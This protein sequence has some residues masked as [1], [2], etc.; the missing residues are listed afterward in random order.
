MYYQ[1]GA[2]VF[3]G[4]FFYMAVAVAGIPPASLL[5]L[6]F[7]F[8]RLLPKLS[9]IQRNIQQVGNTLPSYAAVTRMQARF[10]QE[11]EPP[12]AEPAPFLVLEKG[13]ELRR[14]WFR[15]NKEDEIYALQDVDVVIPAG[16]MTAIIGPSGSGKSTLADLIMGLLRPD[17]G[18]IRVEGRPL[19]GERLYQWRRSVGYVPQETFL[20]H[21]T[22][23]ANLL[24]ALPGAG[25]GDLWRALSLAVADEFVARMP[26]GLDTVVGERGLRLSGGE[27]QRIALARALLRQPALLLLDEATSSL[28]RENEDRIL[29]AVERLHGELTILVIAHRLSTIRHADQIVTMERGRAMKAGRSSETGD[30]TFPEGK[31]RPGH[32]QSGE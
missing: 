31:N 17:R 14:V 19:T 8:A 6:V 27:R 23:R 5:V 7:L 20:F 4:L 25:E 29:E 21:D 18:E 15:Y 22:V 2:A 13:I 32:I 26:Q 10:E 24:W 3:L 28:D 30:F 9:Q 16:G 12:P 1:I 11:K